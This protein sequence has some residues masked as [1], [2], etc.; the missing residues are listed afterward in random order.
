MRE[1]GSVTFTSTDQ[2]GNFRIGDG[3]I[4]D[5]ATGT[6]GGVAFSRGLYAQ[7]TPLIIAL[8]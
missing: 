8:N 2:S 4:I 3:V 1:G 5:Q 6:I 7:I